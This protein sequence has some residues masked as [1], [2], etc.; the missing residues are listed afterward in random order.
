MKTI[1]Q[2]FRRR[3]MEGLAAKW[4]SVR[5]RATMFRWFHNWRAILDACRAGETLPPLVLRNGLTIHHGPGDSPLFIF[6]EIFRERCYTGGGFYRPRPSDTVLDLGANIGLFLV[7][8][9]WRARGIRVHCF[10]PAAETRHR[11]EHNIRANELETCVSVYPF[12]VSDSEG[13]VSLQQA[14]K[15]GV[16]SMFGTRQPDAPPA[17]LVRCIGLGRALELCGARRVD[18]L[19]IDVEGAEIEIIEGAGAEVWERIDR[20]ALEFHDH[21]RPGC[22]ERVTA[23]LATHGFDHIAVDT[24]PGSPHVGVI[25]ASR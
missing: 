12:A 6:N 22:R 9:Q 15:T 13:V 10:E 24:K 11:L 17:E 19:K 8:L 4:R 3:A 23:A 1:S 16:R 20:V 14:P 7:Y 25:W 18:L 21:Y 5:F 2:A